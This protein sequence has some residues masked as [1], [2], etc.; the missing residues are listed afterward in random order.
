MLNKI[1]K[2]IEAVFQFFCGISIVALVLVVA[3]QVI[4]RLIKV[5]LPWAEELARFLMIWLTFIGCSL[6]IHRKGHLSVD[7]FVDL[8][9]RPLKLAIGVLTHLITIAFFGILVV[10]G[11]RLSILSYGTPSSTLQWSMGL[12]YSVLP[13]SAVASIYFTAIDLVEFLRK[14]EGE[15]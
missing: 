6:G 1:T 11:I 12:V 4:S 5:S 8:A 7:F 2:L 9:P 13:I 3:A 10:Y 14:K 15:Q